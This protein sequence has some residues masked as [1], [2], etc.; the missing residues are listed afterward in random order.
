MQDL[1]ISRNKFGVRILEQYFGTP[2][3]QNDAVDQ[4][5]DLVVNYCTDQPEIHNRKIYTSL[6]DLQQ[7]QEAIF[8]GFRKR[9]RSDIRSACSKFIT[10]MAASPRAMPSKIS[11]RFCSIS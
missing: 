7:P 2:I 10:S 4:R 6:I 11:M 3:R 8:K 9:Y 5:Y 1:S